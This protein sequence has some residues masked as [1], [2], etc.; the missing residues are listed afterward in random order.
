MTS[1]HPPL[2]LPNSRNEWILLHASFILIGVLTTL[3][4]PLL[5]YFGQHWSLN[6]AQSGFF[7]TTQYFGSLLGVA[8]TS[9]WL[10]RYG[11]SRVT[12]AGFIAFMLGFAVLG[13]GPWML[14]ATMIGVS[15]LGY[16]L[17][18]P[19]INLR[20]TQLPSRNIAAAV[21][22]LNFSWTVGAV[23][24]PF[25]IGLLVPR[26]GL[27][28]FSTI[29][30]V[31]C[32]ALAF[33][34]F[35]LRSKTPATVRTSSTHS[36]AEWLAHFRVPQ[37][38]PLLLFFF[39]YVG[40]EVSIGGWVATQE[41]RMPG[42]AAVA[43]MI[44]PSVFY[45]LLLFGRGVAPFAL[46]HMRQTVIST[47]GLLL[48]MAGTSLVAFSHTPHTLYAGA[49]IAGFGLAPQYP[50]LVTWLAAIFKEDANWIGALFFG[51]GGLGASALPWL[52]GIIAAQAHSLRAG[53]YVPLAAS[54][55]MVFLV[56]RARPHAAH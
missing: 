22:F 51:S 42:M 29:L 4:G 3:I 5:P 49:A 21:T 34:H 47:G 19:S 23:V 45:G 1:A 30:A 48:A 43:L 6:D 14:A 24:C 40:T 13:V 41:K 26:I 55:V 39:L 20:A 28:G 16:G 52:V 11:F 9:F 38:I 33:L 15:G 10:P 44:A 27:R 31:F 2:P 12:A 18:N 53:L 32:L 36:L 50:I 37:A 54:I 46:S 7:F 8:L 17:A 35:A 25:L 56:L